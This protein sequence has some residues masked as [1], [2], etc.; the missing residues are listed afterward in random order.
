[1]DFEKRIKELRTDL[2]E[3]ATYEFT[4]WLI[5]IGYFIAP[6]AA[7]HHSNHVGGLFKHSQAVAYKLRDMNL[8]WERPESPFVVGYLHDICKTDDYVFTRDALNNRYVDYNND[9]IMPGHGDKSVLMLAG[10]FELTEEEARCIQFHM[11][12]FTDKEQWNYYGKAVERY[13][14]VLWTHSADMYATRVL[15]I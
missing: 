3:L 5:D 14:N 8:K 2:G 10:H 15:G 13:E 9:C 7:K 6:A 1:M 12:A 11:G 4:H